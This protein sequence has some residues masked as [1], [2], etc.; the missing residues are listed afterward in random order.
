[1]QKETDATVHW[2]FSIVLFRPQALIVY[3]AQNSILICR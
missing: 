2:N 1:M 3:N